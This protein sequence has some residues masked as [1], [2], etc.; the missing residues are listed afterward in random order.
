VNYRVHGPGYRLRPNHLEYR[1]DSHPREKERKTRDREG[2][3]V[4]TEYRDHSP[5]YKPRPYHPGFR[6]DYHFR[7]NEWKNSGNASTYEEL[8]YRDH[9]TRQRTSLY[10]HGSRR[11]SHS[12]E[13]KRTSEEVE[14]RDHSSG[15]RPR[16][17][18]NGY[19]RDCVLPKSSDPYKVDAESSSPADLSSKAKSRS[20]SPERHHRE[21]S[22]PSDFS[23]HTK[24]RKDS[25]EHSQ[26]ETL[27]F[28]R[29]GST[30]TGPPN[31]YHQ[32][33]TAN[34]DRDWRSKEHSR[35]PHKPTSKPSN[36]LKRDSDRSNPRTKA[37]HIDSNPVDE[38]RTNQALIPVVI[39]TSERQHPSRDRNSYETKG[40]QSTR[41]DF[42][43]RSSPRSSSPD[44]RSVLTKMHF[45][46]REG[47]LDETKRGSSTRSDR[48]DSPRSSSPDGSSEPNKNLHSRPLIQVI[49]SSSQEILDFP[50]GRTE[51]VMSTDEK[52][53][54]ARSL[55]LKGLT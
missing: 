16:P 47:E 37:I 18:H 50:P 43:D 40:T 29:N 34:N 32:E 10:H 8:E 6:R 27:R 46:H 15:G 51:K 11:D 44:C 1:R 5:G 45:S 48:M 31:T 55:N 53:F 14:D 39:E 28:G 41:S 22:R 9:N 54:L 36:I 12:R 49:A 7:E 4:V 24:T 25:P 30:T 33:R 23:L 38:K 17:H 52:D 35:P 20:S 21:F 26:A 13:N 2:D 3:Y 19:R 42:Q